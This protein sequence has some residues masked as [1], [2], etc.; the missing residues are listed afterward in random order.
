[1]GYNPNEILYGV[2]TPACIFPKLQELANL[3]SRVIVNTVI[4]SRCFY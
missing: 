1:M 3:Y 2:E 4:Q